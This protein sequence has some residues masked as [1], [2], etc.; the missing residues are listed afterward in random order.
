MIRNHLNDSLTVIIR[1]LGE[2]SF[3]FD[4]IDGLQYRL[5]WLYN[6]TVRYLDIGE[7]DERVVR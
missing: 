5:D 2:D 1:D 4:R 6:S 7:V 3:H